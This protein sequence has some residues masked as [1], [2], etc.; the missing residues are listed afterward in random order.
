VSWAGAKNMLCCRTAKVNMV[1]LYP[2]CQLI[3][4]DAVCRPGRARAPQRRSSS[5]LWA[6]NP[7]AAGFV[8]ISLPLWRRTDSADRIRRIS[9]RHPV[10]LQASCWS[11]DGGRHESMPR[12]R[13]TSLWDRRLV[14]AILPA[15]SNLPA[16]TE[17]R[18][19]PG[20]SRGDHL[21]SRT[22]PSFRRLQLATT[23]S[24]ATGSRV[25]AS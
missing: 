3:Y 11:Y 6:I 12:R 23:A 8:A 1:P 24:H 15:A 14:R 20:G 5:L 18:A 10:Q 4:P 22:V 17:Q 25:G 21:P 7:A 2:T 9:Y 13:L 16:L 19:R